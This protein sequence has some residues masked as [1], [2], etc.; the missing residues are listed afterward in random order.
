MALLRG[1]W[2]S[3]L[4]SLCLNLSSVTWEWRLHRCSLGRPGRGLS[5]TR[6]ALARACGVGVAEGGAVASEGVRGPGQQRLRE[7]PSGLA[8]L[9][10]WKTSP[11]TK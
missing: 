10:L 9:V 2:A 1:A 8:E 5:R 7:N 4:A 3:A 11:P 6:A